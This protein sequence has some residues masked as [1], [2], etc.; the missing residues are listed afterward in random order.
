MTYTQAVILIGMRTIVKD[1]SIEKLGEVMDEQVAEQVKG[2]A[3]VSVVTEI[4]D[5]DEKHLKTPALKT[6]KNKAKYGLIYK[7]CVI[8]KKKT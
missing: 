1:L 5:E 6:K 4:L 3:Q 7:P 2:A 8:D